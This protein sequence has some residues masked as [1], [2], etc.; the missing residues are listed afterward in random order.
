[1]RGEQIGYPVTRSKMWL[2]T[3]ATMGLWTYY[4][5][6]VNFQ[7]FRRKEITGIHFCPEAYLSLICLSYYNLLEF[8]EMAGRK[9]E[10]IIKLPKKRAAILMLLVGMPA[11]FLALF[12]QETLYQAIFLL[13]LPLFLES[14]RKGIFSLNDAIQAD[15]K[16]TFGPFEKVIFVVG[17]IYWAVVIFANY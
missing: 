4:W 14:A 16:I 11:F 15:F 10:V 9:Y 7:A 13:T 3:I 1:M 8:I 12:K 5:I 2:L 6:L 17:V